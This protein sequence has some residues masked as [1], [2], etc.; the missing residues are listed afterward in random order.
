MLIVNSTNVHFLKPTANAVSSAPKLLEYFS[1][2]YELIATFSTSEKS[3]ATELWCQLTDHSNTIC[4]LVHEVEAYSIWGLTDQKI[5]GQE[6]DLIDIRPETAR[7]LTDITLWLGQS[8]W[9]IIADLAGFDRAQLFGVD[10][11][12]STLPLPAGNNFPVHQPV[13]FLL[14][15]HVKFKKS[16]EINSI[17]V[18]FQQ[19]VARY[20]GHSCASQVMQDILASM[21]AELSLNA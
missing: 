14:D 19:L 9:L 17:I 13:E 21:P 2:L 16:N 8:L 5:D 1:N 11:L 3:Q 4:L 12:N 6:N 15:E 20:L 18:E 7:E 10:V